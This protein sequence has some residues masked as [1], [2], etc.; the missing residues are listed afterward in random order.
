MSSPAMRNRT[1]HPHPAAAVRGLLLAALVIAAAACSVAPAPVSPPAPEP[2]PAPAPRA[3]VELLGTVQLDP[4]DGS[5]ARLGGLSGLAWVGGD[6]FVAISDDKAHHGP[7]RFYRL[8]VGWSDGGGARVAPP[9]WTELRT[10]TGETLP[11]EGSD[12]EAIA[13]A[14][15]G[16]IWV[17][18][19]GWVE[20]GVAP[21]IASF[22]PAG[23]QLSALP[24]PAG[25]APA[26]DGSAGVRDNLGFEALDLTPDGR[27][28]FAGIENALVQDGPSTLEGKASPARLLRY[29]FTSRQWDGAWIYLVDAPHAV[30]APGDFRVGGLVELVALDPENLLALERSYVKDHGNQVRLFRV[31][32][33]DAEEVSGREAL[34]GAPLPRPVAKELL[35]DLGTLGIEMDNYEGMAL[36]RELADGRRLLLIVSD[37][38]FS[39]EQANRLLLFAVDPAVL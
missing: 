32:L 15:D 19:E 11:S 5:A 3:A 39:P 7:V 27:Y 16:A 1:A 24:L 12:C 37:D 10:A 26:A 31:R 20:R 29:D 30:P 22:D 13:V 21:W 6:E 34:A 8:E 38:N 36:G 35:L 28:L 2:A 4:D 14:P 17:S 33:A 9:A 25:F 23:R 18:T